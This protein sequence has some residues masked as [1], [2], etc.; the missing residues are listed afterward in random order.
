LAVV[1]LV[2]EILAV[3]S[4]AVVIFVAMIVVMVMCGGGRLV[5]HERRG[6]DVCGG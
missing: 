3:V 6:G 1:N 2:E 4:L 5:G